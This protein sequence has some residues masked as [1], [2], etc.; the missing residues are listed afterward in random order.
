[1]TRTDL[2]L[3]KCDGITVLEAIR[4]APSLEQIHVVIL[5][6]QASPEDKIQVQE[7]GGIWCLKPMGFEETKKLAIELMDLCKGRIGTLTSSV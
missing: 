1:M 5:T 7:L 2:H 6:S 4:S 3:P